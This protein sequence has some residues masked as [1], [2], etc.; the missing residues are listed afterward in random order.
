MAASEEQDAEFF[1]PATSMRARW[2][3]SE[4][5]EEFVWL[6]KHRI[7]WFV[8]RPEKKLGMMV[9]LGEGRSPL[10]L[11][12]D[13]GLEGISTVLVEELGSIPAKLGTD[14]LA[15]IVRWWSTATRGA[16]LSPERLR[17][18]MP[19][20]AW[21]HAADERI[22]QLFRRYCAPPAF[23]VRKET[24]AWTLDFFSLPDDGAVRRWHV[25][26]TPRAIRAARSEEVEP[27]GTF[28]WPY[29]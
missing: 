26:G 22:E 6:K 19:I 9:A 23:E 29:L 16:I 1:R 27:A 7:I 14:A 15:R 3:A 10:I 24:G 28:R 2:W 13:R 17:G 11:S 5:T 21:L 4:I 8:S 12:G 20:V 25:E 18:E